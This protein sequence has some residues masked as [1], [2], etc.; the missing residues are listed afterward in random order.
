MK[1]NQLQGKK[2]TWLI[3]LILTIITSLLMS[4]CNS[5]QKVYKVG[6]LSGLNFVADSTDGF[7]EGMNELGYVEGENII[8][9]VQTTDFDMEAYNSIAAKFVE[10]EVDMIFVFPTEA[11]MV[12][13]AATEGTDIPVVFS[14]A[15]VEGMGIIDSV[16]EPGGNITGVR[17]PGPDFAVR[18]FEVLME[19]VPD[20]KN[21]LMPYQRG[22]PIV[23]PQLEILRPVA[24]AAGVTLIDLPA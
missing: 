21:V 14:F 10:D 20:A 22:Y 11:T 16:R 8:Y 6:I 7:K 12:A 3:L 15:L 23:A 18:R 13:K 1:N 5:G 17:Y 19:L 4:G 9:D 24:E 2:T